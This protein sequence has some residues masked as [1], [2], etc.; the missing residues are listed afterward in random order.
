MKTGTI[1]YPREFGPGDAGIDCK[2]VKR[3]LAV[4]NGGADGMNLKTTT[5][6]RRAGEVLA[7]WKKS[8][9]LLHNPYYTEEAH[10]LLQPF[11]DEDGAALMTKAARRIEAQRQRDAYVAAWRWSIAHH[12]QYHYAQVRPIP[13][14]LPAFPTVTVRTDCSGN[15]GLCAKWAKLADPHGMAFNGQGNTSTVLSHCEN[16]PESSARPGDLIVYR[17]GPGD[18]YG[19]HVVAILAVVGDDFEC[20]SHGSEGDPRSIMHSAEL[21]WQ[22]SHGHGTATFCRWLPSLV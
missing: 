11:F 6:A 5:F 1:P 15:T 9:G 17:D 22:A 4:S 16:I 3:A 8:V 2:A 21:A 14:Y 12:A 18:S 10:E 7:D 13:Y 19:H 20:G